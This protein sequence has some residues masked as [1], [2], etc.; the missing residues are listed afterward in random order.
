MCPV[1]A[2]AAPGTRSAAATTSPGRISVLLGMHPQYEHSPPMSSF[3]TSATE[4]PRP[5]QR[6]TAFSPAGPPPTTITSKVSLKLLLVQ[7]WRM[8]STDEPAARADDE[9]QPAELACVLA[10]QLALPV[11]DVVVE[12]LPGVGQLP[13][14]VAAPGFRELGAARSHARAQCSSDDVRRP[15]FRARAVARP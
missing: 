5:A 2:S 9:P 1:T 12:R 11:V 15:G 8:S 6:P 14:A 3:S 10:Q 13:P 4:R 7:V